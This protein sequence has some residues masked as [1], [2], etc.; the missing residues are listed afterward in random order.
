MNLP[1]K[2]TIGRMCAIV[3]IIVI[4]L[5]KPLRE[6]VVFGSVTL[7][8]LLL[9]I[10]FALASFTDFLDGYIAR[11][12]NIVTNFGKFMDPLAD[13]LLVMSTLI[14]LLER[15]KFSVF[16]IGLGFAII[17]IL[18]REFAVTG[19]R[20]IAADNN[21]VIA[22]SKLGKAKTVSQMVMIIFLLIDCY[23]FTFIGGNARDITALVLI[24]I[25]TLLTLISGVD[26]FVKNAHVL[27][28][29]KN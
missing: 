1:N 19:L 9:L 4:S 27:K 8:L 3:V 17:I 13:K 7:D 20:T 29:N 21:Q 25:A 6:I 11:K 18:A 24:S 28:E 12:Q 14:V 2:L 16:G 5:I 10:I 23:P 26:Y 22:A 15:G